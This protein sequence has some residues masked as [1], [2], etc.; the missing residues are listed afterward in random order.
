MMRIS[1]KAAL[2]ALILIF[3]GAAEAQD[4]EIELLLAAEIGRAHV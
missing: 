4:S 2:M 3:Y 1:L